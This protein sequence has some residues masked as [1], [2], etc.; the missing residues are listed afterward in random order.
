MKSI[1]ALLAIASG[2]LSAT[3]ATYARGVLHVTIPYLSTQA[4]P[5]RLTIEVLDP[6]DQP[7]SSIERRVDIGAEKGEWQ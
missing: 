2:I 6:E 5:G 1:F 7:V 3:T 4:G